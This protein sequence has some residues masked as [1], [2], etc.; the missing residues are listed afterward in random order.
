MKVAGVVFSARKTGNGF[1]CMRYC[2]D[3]LEEEGFKTML[4]NAF[5]YEIKPCS[6]CNYECYG[7]EIR[8]KR[9]ED[10]KAIGEERLHTHV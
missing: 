6:H 1:A 3:K 4:V 8:G 5:D 2:L 7:Q 10:F 9:E